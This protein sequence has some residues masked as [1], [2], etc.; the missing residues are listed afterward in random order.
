MK[1]QKLFEPVTIGKLTLKNRTSMA[2][3]GPVG[4]ADSFGGF[5]QRLQDY[6][7]ERAKNDVGLIITGICSVDTTIEGFPTVALPCPTTCPVAFI[8]STRSMN[9]RIHAYGSKIFLQLTGGLGRSA[10]PGFIKNNIAPSEQGNRF[11]PSVIHREMTVEEIQKLIKQFVM[12]AAIAKK[13]GFDGV[14]IHAVHEGYLLDQFAISIYNHRTDMFGGSLENRLRVATEIVKGIK[15]VCGP[16][17]PVSLRYS[18]KSCMKGLRQGGLPGEDYQEAGRDVEEGIQAAKLLV[19]AGY[20]MLNVDAGTYDSWYWN[21]PPMYFGK[22][23]YNEYARILKQHVNV[24]IILAGRMDDPEMAN[25]AIGDC[26]DIVSYGRPLLADPEYV[27]KIRYGREDEVRPCLGCHDGCLGRIANGPVCCAVNPA[28]GREEIYGLQPALRKKNILVIGGGVGGMEAARVAA[29]RGHKVTLVEKSDRL[30]GNLIPGGMPDF[31]HY[32]HE[33][34]RYY[35][36][37]LELLG[38]EVKRNTAMTAAEASAFGAD[39]IVV[40]T[41][42]TAIQLPFAGNK[43][44][45]SA[46]D[47]LMSRVETGS[48]VV[49]VGGGLVG[50]ETALWLAQKGKTVTIVEKMPHILG[51]HGV[52]PHMNQF[53]LEDLLNHERVTIHDNAVVE[54]TAPDQV[55]VRK[56]EEQFQIPCDTLICCVGYRANDG[57]Y[58]ELAQGDVP[59]HNIGDS[60][61]VRNI[62]AAIWDGYELGRNL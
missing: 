62:M 19:E 17:F 8:H 54:Q 14:E 41:G 25:A 44:A 55:T 7:V 18:L 10:L 61:K 33:L 21:H 29:L 56:G 4:Y 36:R 47:V 9:D 30:G 43:T 2:P 1:Y 22:G 5:N 23:V 28:C 37:Q 40:A 60:N 35:E 13:A 34:I 32:D 38:V 11:D 3:M 45:V 51:G 42:S 16:D 57:L 49:V 15:K 31:K 6:Y 26:C 27:T 50:C 24:P 52:V 48:Q 20:D 12:S 39:E 58:N 46:E 59:V 53:M